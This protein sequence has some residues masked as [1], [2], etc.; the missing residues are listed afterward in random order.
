VTRSK[1]RLF[2]WLVA[3]LIAYTAV[4]WTVN[5]YATCVSSSFIELGQPQTTTP[6]YCE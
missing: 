2:F 5:D 4:A 3:F 1:S 6:I